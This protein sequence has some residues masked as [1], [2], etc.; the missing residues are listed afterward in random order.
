M[1]N[2]RKIKVVYQKL[3][4]ERA[5]GIADDDTVYV[6]PRLTGK[7]Q[8]EII[9]HESLHVLWPEADEEEIERKAI[10]LTNTLWYEHYRRVDNS[11]KIPLQDGKK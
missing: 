10:I 5:Y 8:L 7:K 11:N 1:A 2:R 9:V 6:D 3:G 4:R